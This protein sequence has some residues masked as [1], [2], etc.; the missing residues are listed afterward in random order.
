MKCPFCSST[1]NSV[2]NSRPL[3]DDT[4]IRRRRECLKCHKRYNTYERLEVLPVMVVKRDGRRELFDRNKVRNGILAAC[5][6][7]AVSTEI[8]EKMVSD[9]E[10]ITQELGTEIPASSIGEIIIKKLKK[11]DLVAYIRFVSVYR[12]FDSI[13]T[14]L[15]EIKS[16]KE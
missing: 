6:K 12:K 2:I 8:I 11:I 13:K 10:T 15:K 5:R 1:N 9:I 4:V 16:L 3:E 14:F 7:R